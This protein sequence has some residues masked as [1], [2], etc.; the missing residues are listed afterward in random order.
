MNHHFDTGIATKYGV[1]VAIFL[2]NVAFWTLHNQANEKHLH[3]GRYWTYNSQQAFSKLFPYWTRQNIR[4]IISTCT[5]ENLIIVGNF[6][7]SG[8]DRTS[9]YALTETGLALF[10]ELDSLVSTNQCIGWNQPMDGLESTNG[11]VAINQPIP[12]IKPNNKTIDKEKSANAPIP[13]LETLKKYE[14]KTPK[15]L[16]EI[17]KKYLEKAETLL[18]ER[19]MTL[20]DYLD[21]L[22]NRC[23]RRLLPY[24]TNGVERQNGFG[25]ILRPSFINSTLTGSWEGE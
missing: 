11:M 23:P 18:K 13:S 20:E 21:Y 24:I 2:Q 15:K 8:Y 17:Q 5:Q 10:P 22:T 25:N 1:N 6:N 12:D 14:I 3:E 4:T 19:E 16:N 9:W 7:Q